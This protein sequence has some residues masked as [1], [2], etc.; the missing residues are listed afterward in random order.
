M[1]GLKKMTGTDSF[2]AMPDK[3]KDCQVQAEAECQT[4]KYIERIQEDC[5]CISWIQSSGLT[6]KVMDMNNTVIYCKVISYSIQ[7]MYTERY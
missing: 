5:G 6:H 3:T 7:T 4:E 2:L 1:S